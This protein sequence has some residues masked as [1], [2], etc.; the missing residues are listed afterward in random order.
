M[1]DS[2]FATIDFSRFFGPDPGGSTAISGIQNFALTMP[3]AAISAPSITWCGVFS[4]RMRSWKVPG[5]SSLP[6]QTRTLPATSPCP[7]TAA[8]FPVFR[9]DAS[10]LM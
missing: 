2:N 6:L 9:I 1:P 7:A 8:H 3:A 10:N 5:W 4:G